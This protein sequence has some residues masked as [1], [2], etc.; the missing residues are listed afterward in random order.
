MQKQ[1]ILKIASSK[2]SSW[3]RSK[4]RKKNLLSFLYTGGSSTLP[5]P[6]R[7]FFSYMDEL[8]SFHGATIY[9]FEILSKQFSKSF[10]RDFHE[11]F[12]EVFRWFSPLEFIW[13][14]PKFIQE[15]LSK[16]F[17]FNVLVFVAKFISFNSYYRSSSQDCIWETVGEIPN[18]TYKG[19]PEQLLVSREIQR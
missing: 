17:F 7:S 1:N 2:F 19:I 10:S 18:E 8:H 15:F 13:I 12:V 11:T 4:F 14:S 9:S 6:Q 16:F 3:G 5:I